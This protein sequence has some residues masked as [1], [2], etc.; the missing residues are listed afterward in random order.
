[1][2]GT[3]CGGR[4]HLLLALEQTSI[5]SQ[6]FVENCDLCLS[7]TVQQRPSVFLFVYTGTNIVSN[8]YHRLVTHNTRQDGK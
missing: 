7:K 2:R 4:L 3:V 5:D 6:L 8:F 1:M